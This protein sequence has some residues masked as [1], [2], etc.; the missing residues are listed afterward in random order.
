MSAAGA[1]R[2]RTA[3]GENRR[4]IDAAVRAAQRA[5]ERVRYTGSD[6]E[7]YVLNKQIGEVEADEAI[8]KTDEYDLITERLNVLSKEKAEQKR[9][10]A[11]L[12][13]ETMMADLFADETKKTNVF[14]CGVCLTE[15][16]LSRMRLLMP[17]NHVF[18]AGCIAQLKEANRTRDPG[19]DEKGCPKCRGP[20]ASV[21]KPFF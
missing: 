16:P 14:D 11:R 7:T 18:C 5:A 9:F 3:K 10:D 12:A 1:K 6:L 17:C 19:I 13:H 15:K 21:V 4:M 8:E 20:I 2:S